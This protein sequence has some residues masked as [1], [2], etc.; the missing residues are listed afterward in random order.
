MHH[1]ICELSIRSHPSHAKWLRDTA[2]RA[3]TG[4][5]GEVVLA[6]FHNGSGDDTQ[7]LGHVLLTITEG[8]D[9]QVV[10]DTT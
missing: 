2:V 7:N 5:I 3:L 1:P 8:G 10:L 6:F 9:E 4:M